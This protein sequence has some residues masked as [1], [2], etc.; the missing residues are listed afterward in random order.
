MQKAINLLSAIGYEC[1]RSYMANASKKTRQAIALLL[2]PDLLQTSL[3]L[4]ANAST[5]ENTNAW[6]QQFVHP[7]SA[8]GYAATTPAPSHLNGTQPQPERAAKTPEP[9]HRE[10]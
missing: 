4:K 2:S 8:F 5:D 1:E 6:I 9:S 3:L 10:S 7:I